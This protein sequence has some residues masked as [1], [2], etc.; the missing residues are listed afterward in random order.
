MKPR[1]SACTFPLLLL[2]TIGLCACA[3]PRDELVPYMSSEGVANAAYTATY[4]GSASASAKPPA[5]KTEEA[6]AERP[7]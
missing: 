2:G 4:N 6:A 7:S 1:P 3:S 5:A